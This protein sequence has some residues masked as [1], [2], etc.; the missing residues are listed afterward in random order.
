MTSGMTI[1]HRPLTEQEIDWVI[2]GIR[3]TPN[4]TAY[5]KSE[6]RSFKSPIIAEVDGNFAGVSIIWPINSRWLEMSMSLVLPEYRGMGIG[7]KL[8]EEKWRESVSTGK[9]IYITS[10]TEPILTFI[11]EKKMTF[12]PFWRLPLVIK[13]DLIMYSCSSL[14]RISEFF[15]KLFVFPG[16][17]AFKYAIRLSK[18]HG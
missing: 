10:R 12:L 8:F 13:L 11:K 17:P 4:I 15:R 18:S 5:T 6:L 14:Y 3:N 7:R 2:E 1:A 9:N 16:Q